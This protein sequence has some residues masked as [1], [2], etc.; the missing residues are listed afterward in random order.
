[1]AGCPLDTDLPSTLGKLGSSG[2]EMEQGGAVLR[3]YEKIRSITFPPTSVK[4][5]SLPMCLYV[6]RS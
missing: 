5:K 2:S 6:R 1:M 4:R 3:R